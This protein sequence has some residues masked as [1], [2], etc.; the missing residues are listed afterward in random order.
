MLY[1]KTIG[2]IFD[3]LNCAKILFFL[4]NFIDNS[5]VLMIKYR[6]LSIGKH[7]NILHSAS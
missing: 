4:A 6:I 2:F 1:L 5:F 3:T 7:T